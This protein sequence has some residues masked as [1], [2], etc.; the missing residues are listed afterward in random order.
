M[1]DADPVSASRQNRRLS[2]GP[3]DPAVIRAMFRRAAPRY[4]LLNHLL[5]A[6]LDHRWRA[7]AA[8]AVPR[9]AR[10][11]LDVC[12]GTGDLAAALR[13]RL[14][15][16]AR[17][18][19]CDFARAMLEGARGKLAR[20]RQG[21]RVALVEADALALPLADGTMDAAVCGFGLRN[22]ADPVAG[23]A[24]AART[25][26]PGGRVVALEFHRPAG[27]GPLAR[28]FG[29]YFRRV[30]PTLGGRLSDRRAYRHLVDSI[31]AFGPPEETAARMREAGLE[32]VTIKPLPGGIAA[33]YIGHAPK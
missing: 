3:P 25:V 9:G 13:K 24:E 15:P 1:P 23:L 11:V 12:A 32:G 28:A 4:D 21:H 33:L 27:R 2:P 29:L 18:V 7:Q 6:G 5:S 20:A 31:R 19:A 14:G 16:E 17:V 30:L 10:T 8:A 22:L 26:R